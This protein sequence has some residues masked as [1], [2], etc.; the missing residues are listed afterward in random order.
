MQ[1]HGYGALHTWPKP[2]AMEHSKRLAAATLPGGGW[3]RCQQQRLACITPPSFW[4]YPWQ[5]LL[6]DAGLLPV[7]SF[8]QSVSVGVSANQ[9][10]KTHL[11]LA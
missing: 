7:S 10:F 2:G 11:A 4:A 9:T 5:W 8:R 6:Q 1:L 3:S